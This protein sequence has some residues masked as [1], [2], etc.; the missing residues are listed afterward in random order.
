M[1][2]KEKGLKTGNAGERVPLRVNRYTVALVR[3]ENNTPEYAARLRRLYEKTA[4]T[5]ISMRY[6]DGYA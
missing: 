5:G 3:P 6:L 2:K 4:R 1:D